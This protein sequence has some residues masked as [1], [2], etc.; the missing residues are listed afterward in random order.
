[1]AGP[2]IEE[3]TNADSEVRMID[4]IKHLIQINN[5]PLSSSK[6][7]RFSHVAQNNENYPY[8]KTALEKRMI[9]STTNPNLVISC[10]VY[11]VMKGLAE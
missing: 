1:M 5:I 10:D 3:K 4:A 2:S 11:I 8:M 7:V 6:N 9:G